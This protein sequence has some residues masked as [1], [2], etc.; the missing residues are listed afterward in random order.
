MQREWE[1]RTQCISCCIE[2]C[3][4]NGLRIP[5]Q[6]VI[7]MPRNTP[8]QLEVALFRA[9]EEENRMRIRVHRHS[10]AADARMFAEDGDML[11][12]RQYH[13]WSVSAENDSDSFMSDED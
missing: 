4:L 12:A 9:R 11:R 5:K 7:L 3:R 10:L 8:Q 2:Q 13:Q 6:R 1:R